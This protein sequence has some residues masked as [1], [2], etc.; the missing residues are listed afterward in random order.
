[1]NESACCQTTF[2]LVVSFY[3]TY[4]YYRQQMNDLKKRHDRDIK[5]VLEDLSGR[6]MNSKLL[7]NKQAAAASSIGTKTS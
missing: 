1:M 3:L 7:E 4:M 5:S 6:R 2:G